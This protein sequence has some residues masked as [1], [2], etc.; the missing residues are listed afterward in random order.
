MLW[1]YICYICYAICPLAPG[2]STHPSTHPSMTPSCLPRPSAA[3]WSQ[4]ATALDGTAKEVLLAPLPWVAMMAMMANPCK[5]P[6]CPWRIHVIHVIHVHSVSIH[7]TPCRVDSVDPNF[8]TLARSLGHS[9]AA[10]SFKNSWCHELRLSQGKDPQCIFL[11][12][13]AHLSTHSRHR[14]KWRLS[15][16]NH[17]SKCGLL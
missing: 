17:Y 9:S 15:S 13:H 3:L 12:N 7:V 5:I 4:D 10:L 2:N 8:N 11:V 6:W 1:C 14:G 16:F